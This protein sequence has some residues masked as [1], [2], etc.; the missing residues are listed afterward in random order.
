MRVSLE[1]SLVVPERHSQAASHW[2]SDTGCRLIDLKL[3]SPIICD[4]PDEIFSANFMIQVVRPRAE[5]IRSLNLT[6]T[7]VYDICCF[8]HYQG[9]ED[10]I[11][12]HVW[13]FPNL[14]F[15]TLSF[16]TYRAEVTKLTAFQF[17]P[18]LH[19]VE[20]YNAFSSNEPNINLPWAQLT[21]LTIQPIPE[22]LFRIVIPQCSALETGC[23]SINGRDSDEEL[24]IVNLTLTRL[25]NFNIQFF[26][27]SDPSLFNGIHF[28]SLDVFGTSYGLAG[29]NWTA[30]GHIFRQLAP[31]TTLSLG[32]HINC[33]D[34]IDMLCETKNVTT[35]E[36]EFA[37]GHG[38]VLRALT[39]GEEHEVLLKLSVLHVRLC[40]RY[41]YEPV[42]GLGFCENGGI[43]VA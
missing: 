41:P 27:I 4:H 36:V 3:S 25:T 21:S 23:F 20:L 40:Y 34:M 29:F 10:T 9:D 14:E 43:E 13:S 38:E 17:M 32:G 39:L 26:G 16:F 18:K 37:Q 6:F 5:R 28:P 19:T 24:P 2:F 7:D 12:Q 15:L 22:S 8:L 33:L 35:F 30:P 1:D 31:I 42:C 11:P